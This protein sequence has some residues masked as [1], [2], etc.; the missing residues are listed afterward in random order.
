MAHANIAKVVAMSMTVILAWLL[1]ATVWSEDTAN[2]SPIPTMGPA[3][4][5][6]GK[7]TFAIHCARCHGM[8]GEG[9]EGPGLNRNKLKHASDD[10]ALFALLNEGLPG[11]GMPATFGP[12]DQQMWQVAAYVRS[13]GALPAESLPGNPKIGAQIYANKGGCASCHIT[14]GVG[15]GVGPELTDVGLRRNRLYLRRALT[16]PDADYPLQISRQNGQVNAF[17]TVRVVSQAGELEGMRVNEDEF[18][19]QI[20]DLA[21]DL[22]SFD[23]R[24]LLNYRKALGHSLMPG[25][26]TA[27]NSDEVNDLVSFLMELKGNSK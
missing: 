24:D 7:S 5:A 10:Q 16:N 4:L 1:P 13:L 14:N 6:A 11:T 18:S 19:V 21:G 2:V 22:H 26:D 15:R 12:N 27:L 8:R 20:R 25:Y 17:M 3:D 23:K 9:G